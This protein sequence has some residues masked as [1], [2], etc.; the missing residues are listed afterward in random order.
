MELLSLDGLTGAFAVMSSAIAA[1]WLHSAKSYARILQDNELCQKN[2]AELREE[3]GELK[4]KQEGI[5]LMAESVLREVRS[6]KR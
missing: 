5:T 6:H 3:F 2:F 1:Q 4:G